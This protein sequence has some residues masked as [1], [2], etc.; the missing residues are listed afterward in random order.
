MIRIWRIPSTTGLSVTA[1]NGP[2]TG[3]RVDGE[4]GVGWRQRVPDERVVAGVPVR[5]GHAAEHGARGPVLLH[6]ELVLIP[7]ELGVVVVDVGHGDHHDNGRGQRP[8]QPA[9]RGH[10]GQLVRVLRLPVQRAFHVHPA[11]D[12]V[13]VQRTAAAAGHPVGDTGV[14]AAIRVQRRHL[15]DLRHNN[16]RRS[17]Y[18]KWFLTGHELWRVFKNV[19]RYPRGGELGLGLHLSPPNQ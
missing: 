9:V 8:G 3:V 19:D 16:T 13:H 10:H 2:L 18:T 7:V 15:H 1:R 6:V 12:G 11:R 14:V 4:A 5:R 17:N